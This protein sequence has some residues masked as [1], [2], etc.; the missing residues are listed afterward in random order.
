MPQ[1]LATLLHASPESRLS[2]TAK[3]LFP[4]AACTAAADGPGCS[5]YGNLEMRVRTV[6]L[7]DAEA[8]VPLF[9]DLGYP[10]NATQIRTRLKR[11]TGD[12][13]YRALI[14]EIDGNVAGFVGLHCGHHF[15]RDGGWV[16]ITALVTAIRYQRRGVGSALL[17]AAE[18]W[19]EKVRAD[20]LVLSSSHHRS[21]E[22]HA[23][24]RSQGYNDTGLRFTK[25]L[26]PRR[27]EEN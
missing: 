1:K 7:D 20:R 4:A 2:P 24:Y 18:D 15:E 23:F 27:Q 10:T 25:S 9:C 21:A 5:C 11:L 26:T 22:A 12:S 6:A 16:E 3:L 17:A 8:L 14:V 13:T 19:A